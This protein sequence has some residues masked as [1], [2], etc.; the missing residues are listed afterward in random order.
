MFKAAC[1][2]AE[3]V[4]KVAITQWVDGTECYTELIILGELD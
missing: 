4:M 3:A 2:L 1:E